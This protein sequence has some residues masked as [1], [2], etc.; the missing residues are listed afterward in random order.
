MLHLIYI[1][2]TD[3]ERGAE[4]RG[5][6]SCTKAR[7]VVVP[8]VRWN[9]NR[10]V[11]LMPALLKTR[12][13]PVQHISIWIILQH[14]TTNQC[15]NI[16]TIRTIKRSLRILTATQIPTTEG[17]P[18]T[19]PRLLVTRATIR[20]IAGKHL[21]GRRWFA[22]TMARTERRLVSGRQHMLG[23]AQ[24]DIVKCRVGLVAAAVCAVI[25]RRSFEFNVID[26][27]FPQF[28]LEENAYT[29]MLL[30]E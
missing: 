3:L 13:I 9:T 2:S 15:T 6:I 5:M 22:Q 24:A 20:M 25:E 19:N 4:W 11:R 17:S 10:C 28:R 14:C 7:F 16:C 18:S 29:L 21:T 1:W 26:A 27:W 12:I 23:R 8:T 30:K